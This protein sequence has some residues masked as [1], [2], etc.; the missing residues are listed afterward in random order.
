M[1]DRLATLPGL[2]LLDVQAFEETNFALLVHA[3]VD[4]RDQL[5]RLRLD[6][7]GRSFTESQVGVLARSY[8]SILRRIVEC[9]DDPV[10]F[11]F[12]APP[13]RAVPGRQEAPAH[14][15]DRFNAQVAA[16]P[17]KIAVALGDQ[18][19]T[20]G[21]L[22]AESDQIGQYLLALGASSRECVGIAMDRSPE[23]IAAVLGILKTGAACLPLD[24]TYPPERLAAMIE[25]ARPLRILAHSRHAGK[26]SD[27]SLVVPVEPPPAAGTQPGPT[28]AFPERS[29]EDIACILFTSGSTGQPK[30]VE[31]PHRPF[32]YYLEWQL[33]APS[34]AVGDSTLQFAPL[35]FDVS[36]QE[37]FSTLSG[38]GILQLIEEQERRD[39]AALV[40][41]LD[42]TGVARVF[43]PYVALQQLAETAGVLGIRPRRLRVIIS[44]GEQLRVT[45]EIRQLC[46]GLPGT[47]LENQYGPTETH[48]V[49][50]FTMSGDPASFPSLPPVGPPMDYLEVHVLDRDMRPVPPGVAGEIYVGGV[51]LAHGYRR[52]PEAH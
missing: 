34:G 31:L 15:I 7:H 33:A 50:K 49:S 48:L 44:S 38:G 29:L 19:W 1:L 25:I 51:G 5:T 23:M 28:P 47:V 12:L 21:R 11:G 18:Q 36:F 37:I 43:V 26:L 46:A 35:S 9:P 6:C 45:E 40:R 4:P 41:L 22:G 24:V 3:I 30:G 17:E 14:V 20:Y 13:P 27:Q 2:A 16:Q 42:S 39:P 52:Q 10:S 8:L 32:S